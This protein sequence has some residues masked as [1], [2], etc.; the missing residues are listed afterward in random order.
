MNKVNLYEL[1]DR[2]TYCGMYTSK[3]LRE[4]LQ[5]SSQNISVA[6]RLNSLIK[7]RYRLK[8]FEIECEVAL[9]K[10][11]A[12]LCA[13]W[14]E[15]RTRMLK[16]DGKWFREEGEKPMETEHS[17]KKTGRSLTAQGTMIRRSA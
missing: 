9:N 4:M 15:T 10:Y 14:D 1:Y 3:Q 6:A 2:N 7:R 17:N 11:S 5:V 8:H 12:Q 13:D 16:G